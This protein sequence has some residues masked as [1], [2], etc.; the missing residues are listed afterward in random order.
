MT[1]TMSKKAMTQEYTKIMEKLYWDDNRL[2]KIR[3]QSV[4]YQMHP[5]FQIYDRNSARKP[6]ID[7]L[8]LAIARPSEIY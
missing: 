1:K 3:E 6:R 8:R 2:E 7:L 5:E 4:F